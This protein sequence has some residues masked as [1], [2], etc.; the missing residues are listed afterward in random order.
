[1]SVIEAVLWLLAAWVVVSLSLALSWITLVYIRKSLRRG[2]VLGG[3]LEDER[4][5]RRRRVD[6]QIDQAI[7]DYRE[8]RP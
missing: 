1:M 5:E 2:G 4:R 8:R 3:V 7:R 6:Q